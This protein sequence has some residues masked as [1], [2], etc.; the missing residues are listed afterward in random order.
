MHDPV[1]STGFDLGSMPPALHAA[2]RS[3]LYAIADDE[4]LIGHRD[5]EWTGLGPILEEDIAF[6][7]MAQDEL[8]HALLW[9]KLL[10]QMGEADPDRTVF[11]RP[12]AD[13]RN[14]RFC[15]LPRGD[16]AFSLVRQYLFDLAEALRYEALAQSPWREMADTATKIRQEEKYH[17]LHGRAY[18][19]RLG[20]TNSDSRARLQAALDEA[21]PY[22]L[23]LWEAPEGE[24]L[25][26]AAGVVPSS[27][28]LRLRWLTVI[29]QAFGSAGLELPIE[30]SDEAP[31][32]RVE[33][34]EGGRSG[35]HGLDLD[36]ILEA[37]QTLFLSDPEAQW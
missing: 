17:L 12:A 9:Y 19:D 36:E 4:L 1:A 22:A 31:V 14:A 29:R 23:G 5:S 16:Y 15:E 37:M 3:Y 10:E 13:W 24:P 26:V 25:L 18:L 20:K 27:S 6:S 2:A 8:G 21:L 11:Q 7:S 28:E 34:I 33:A 32:C 30:G 35:A